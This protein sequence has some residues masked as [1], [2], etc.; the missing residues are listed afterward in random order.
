LKIIYEE[1]FPE[2]LSFTKKGVKGA[3]SPA[4]QGGEEVSLLYP[5]LTLTIRSLSALS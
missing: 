1:D 2:M 5:N 3:E 4:L